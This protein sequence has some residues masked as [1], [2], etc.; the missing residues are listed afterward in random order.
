MKLKLQIGMSP[1]LSRLRDRLQFPPTEIFPWQPILQGIILNTRP[2][3]SG[4]AY[5][6]IWNKTAD[7]S[8]LRTFTKQQTEALAQRLSGFGEGLVAL[9]PDTVDPRKLLKSL[10]A[11]TRTRLL[12]RNVSLRLYCAKG[13]GWMVVDCAW[14]RTHAKSPAPCPRAKPISIRTIVQRCL[15]VHMY[16]HAVAQK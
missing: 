12:E 14:A 13:I 8:L 5:A 1:Y 4:E 2:G 15:V 6:K 3:R 10:E 16:C 9:E 7:E 11:L